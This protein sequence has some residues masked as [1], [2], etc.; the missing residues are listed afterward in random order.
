MAIDVDKG[1]VMRSTP[2][3]IVVCAIVGQHVRRFESGAPDPT[4]P[5]MGDMPGYFFNEHGKEV[6]PELARSAGY[7]V[8]RL[9]AERR[10]RERIGVATAAIE[11]EFGITQTVREIVAERGDF[12]VVHI[13]RDQYNVEDFEGNVMNTRGP[14]AKAIAMNILENL[15]PEEVEKEMEPEPEEAKA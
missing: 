15:T 8:D 4:S 1:V 13:G 2:E 14:I 11:K 12:K 7:D 5:L 6:S 10:K 3:G 9:M